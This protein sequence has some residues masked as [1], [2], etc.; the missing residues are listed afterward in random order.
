MVYTRSMS[1]MKEADGAVAPVDLNSA[2]KAELIDSGCV[3]EI[4]AATLI[5][6]RGVG[7]Q[8]TLLSLTSSDRGDQDRTG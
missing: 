3:S 8:L 2:S 4:D 7:G 1:K 6:L 5:Q